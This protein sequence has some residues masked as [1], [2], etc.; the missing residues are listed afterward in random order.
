MQDLNHDWLTSGHI[1][2]EYKQYLF[3]AWMQKVKNEYHNT[4][5]YP[6][7]SQVIEEHRKLVHLKR[8]QSGLDQAFKGEL[9]TIDFSKMKMVYKKI[10]DHPD[11]SAYLDALMEFAL[12]K[13]KDA[14][15]EGK[16]IYDFVEEQMEFSPVGLM[17]LYKNEG[18]LMV[19]EED[20]N[21]VS[22]FRYIKSLIEIENER[23]QQLEL[24]LVDRHTK[25]ITDTF[26]QMKLRLIKRFK[27][28]PNPA[29]FLVRS[30]L[31]VPLNETLLPV[32]RRKLLI[33][34]AA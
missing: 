8:S 23:L 16:T 21:E 31:T 17:P 26:E 1:D 24:K 2:A 19:Y 25:R 20:K 9:S 34:L 5:L 6:A 12:P 32:A 18:Y 30:K 29:A 11:L 27:E 7:L 15:N 22:A 4:R 28:L 3:L 10:D 13:L 14:I 33:E